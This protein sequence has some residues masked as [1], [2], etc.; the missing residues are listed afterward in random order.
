VLAMLLRVCVGRGTGRRLSSR[1]SSLAG[2]PR[3][4]AAG[5]GW[6]LGKLFFGGRAQHRLFVVMILVFAT[7][8]IRVQTGRLTSMRAALVFPLVCAVG[9]ALL[10]TH[11]H[12]LT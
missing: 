3:K 12:A 5:S 10:L 8:E 7:F 9:G 2:G 11:T 1:V 4:L 6:I